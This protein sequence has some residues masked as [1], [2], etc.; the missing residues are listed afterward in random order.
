MIHHLGNIDETV[1]PNGFEMVECS[2]EEYANH[3]NECYEEEGVTKEELLD[4]QKRPTYN[5]SL[6]IAIKDKKTNKVVATIIGEIDIRIGEGIIEWVQ[7][8]EEYRRLGL[9]KYLVCEN[10][11]KMKKCAS[12]AVVSG[13]IHSKSNPFK[14]YEAC[15]FIDPV[16]WHVIQK[17]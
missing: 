17:D 2:V 7:V 11:R 15:G 1:L 4:Y 14:L 9:G 16:I 3:I 5:P 13:N 6:W 12:F 8:S 10:L